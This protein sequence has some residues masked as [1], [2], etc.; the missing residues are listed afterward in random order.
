M[1]AQTKKPSF[2]ATTGGKIVKLVGISLTIPL[3]LLLVMSNNELEKIKPLVIEQI[4]ETLGSTESLVS[5]FFNETAL[6]NLVIHPLWGSLMIAFIFGIVFSLALKTNQ[7]MPVWIIVFLVLIIVMIAGMGSWAIPVT[8]V[9]ISESVVNGDYIIPGILMFW[10][11]IGSVIVLGFGAN[12]YLGK[13]AETVS[14]TI[15]GQ[16]NKRRVDSQ[17]KLKFNK[18]GKK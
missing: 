18:R 3:I 14:Y 5:D 10:F 13:A 11:L 12:W 16:K 2:I 6:G 7:A 15:S 1:T 8:L 17:T 4:A 9:Y